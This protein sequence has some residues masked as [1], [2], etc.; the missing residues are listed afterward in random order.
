MSLPSPT[1]VRVAIPC[2]N[3]A[4]YIGGLL[5][6][7]VHAD[8]NGIDLQVWVCDGMSDDGTRAIVLEHAARNPFIRLVDNPART[9]PQ[10]M[11]IGLQDLEFDVG[12]ILGAHASVDQAF[13]R[14]N[15]AVLN[16]HPDV[17]CAGGVMENVYDDVAARRIGMAMGHPF[18]VGNAHFR[19]GRAEGLVDTVAFGAYRREVFERVG[20]F[21]ETLV[22]NQDDEFNYR[23]VQ[24]GFGIYLSPRI[25]SM[26]YVRASLGKLFRQYYQYGYWKVYVN[27]KH[28][29]VTTLRQVVPALFVAFLMVGAGASLF[30]PWLAW[31]YGAGVL[32]Y[33]LAAMLSAAQASERWRDLPGVLRAFV[34]L[35]LAYGSGYLYGLCDLLLLGRQPRE[36]DKALTR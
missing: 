23:V 13:L 33:V 14:E 34:V 4:A 26:Y 8:R 19:T 18:G 35:H 11:N 27:R 1:R 10:A 30:H 28:R 36:R 2:R 12:V 9:T 3:E 32:F 5:L 20:F 15:L 16:A 25:R 6:S 29:T 22:R 7:L 17:G 31:L 24:A 21:D